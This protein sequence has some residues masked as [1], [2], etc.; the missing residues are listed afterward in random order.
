MDKCF[1]E[2]NKIVDYLNNIKNI[3]VLGPSTAMIPKINNI[4]CVQIIIKYK[5]YKLIADKINYIN[6]NYRESKTKVILEF[7]PIRL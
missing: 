2:G 5:E 1:D 7:N 6:N 4:Y 3:S